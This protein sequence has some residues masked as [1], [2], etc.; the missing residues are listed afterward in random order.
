MSKIN[1]SL[2]V[3]LDDIRAIED[4]IQGC[5][6]LL[7][8]L[9]YYTYDGSGSDNLHKSFECINNSLYKAIKD[10]KQIR[11]GVDYMQDLIRSSKDD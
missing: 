10:L 9:T 5:T 2:A 8:G 3:S 4:N 6:V 11:D 1:W 7:D